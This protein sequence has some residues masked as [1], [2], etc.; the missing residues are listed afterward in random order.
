MDS[1][2]METGRKDVIIVALVCLFLKTQ[3][4]LRKD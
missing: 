4:S 2:R 3:R 1:R